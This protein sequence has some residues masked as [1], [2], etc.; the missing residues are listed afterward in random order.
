VLDRL[1]LPHSL[2]PEWQGTAPRVPPAE[3]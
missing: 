3:P 2:A 1:G